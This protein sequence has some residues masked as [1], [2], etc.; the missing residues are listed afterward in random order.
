VTT[1][2]RLQR[3]LEIRPGE[4][5][6]LVNL[7]ALALLAV[8]QA[9]LIRTFSDALFL[10]KLGVRW[11]PLFFLVS[12]LAF[13][14]ATALYSWLRG[15]TS[16]RL[17]HPLML[18]LFSLLG[19]A[20][21]APLDRDVPV[22]LVVLGLA[23][24]SPLVNV[25]AWS[26]ILERLNPREARR[27]VPLVSAGAT[28]GGILAGA[29]AIPFI[30]QIG[31]IELLGPITAC[32]LLLA[33]LV[34]RASLP[35]AADRPAGPPPSLGRRQ[36]FS[37]APTTGGPEWRGQPAADDPGSGEAVRGRP[38]LL[39][40]P[41]LLLLAVSVLLMSLST[42]LIDYAFKVQLQA[43]LGSDIA[44]MAV[45][46]GY[47]H[48]LTNGLILLVQLFV[49]GRV[50]RHLGLQTAFAIHPLGVLVGLVG[51]A[52]APGLVAVAA[53]KLVDGLLKFTFHNSTIDMA[54]TPV[55]KLLR[56]RGRALL[57]GTMHPLGGFLAGA[58]LLLLDVVVGEA[59]WKVLP[60]VLAS[61][62]VWL[63]FAL[64]LK[65][66]YLGQLQEVLS[67]PGL[68][69]TQELPAVWPG[70]AESGAAD[71]EDRAAEPSRL[72][73]RTGVIRAVGGQVQRLRQT[74]S[75]GPL[76]RGRLDRD[77]QRLFELLGHLGDPAIIDL[78]RRRYQFG[79]LATKANAVELLEMHL[80]ERRVAEAVALLDT[81]APELVEQ[82]ARQ[83]GGVTGLSSRFRSL[84]GQHQ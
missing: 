42:N 7:S 36:I 32:N 67:L 83:R 70:P 75:A 46:L 9:V 23:L 68:G 22:F 57:K 78:V 76:E 77:L 14:P 3:W 82:A 71:E 17:L 13:L 26:C 5:R 62:G 30:Q 47:Y 12:A 66:S 25:I 48:A 54:L 20:A 33:L 8:A 52:L 74:V 45:F 28:F 58:L 27:L 49:V 44:R 21:H 2:S 64:R 63:F 11:L 24:V 41:L 51:V 15:R 31:V 43:E 18:L 37:P 73:T 19:L 81:L 53:W 69:G 65:R 6:R 39:A 1:A 40:N 4:G 50:V 35:P 60:A 34:G 16:S 10:D 80:D 29:L 56:D 84:F 79:N 72:D 59:A 61:A 38:H 55:P